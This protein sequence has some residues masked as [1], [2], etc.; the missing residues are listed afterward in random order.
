M[1]KSNNL[2]YVGVAAAV[3][4]IM[5]N[6]GNPS[7]TNAVGD[8]SINNSKVINAL[9]KGMLIEKF[10]VSKKNSEQAFFEKKLLKLSNVEIIQLGLN[11]G[12]YLE[13]FVGD[14]IHFNEDALNKMSKNRLINDFIKF[15][16]ASGDS[17]SNLRSRLSRLSNFQ[18]VLKGIRIGMRPGDFS[19]VY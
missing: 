1:S 17:Q 10:L 9:N 5:L 19:T 16:D 4:L 7:N 13:W 14:F 15:F 8:L 11:A 18:I 12:S 3:G 2:M 6:K